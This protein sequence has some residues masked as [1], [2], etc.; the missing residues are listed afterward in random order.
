MD[1]DYLIKKWLNNELNEVEKEAFNTLED[2]EFNEYI[3][4]NAQHFKASNFYKIDDFETFKAKY[5][6][7]KKPIKKLNW[8][9]PL[10]KIACVL[11]ISIGVYF[12]LFS[13][14]ITQIQ[15]VAGEKATVT[16]PDQSKVELNVL[17]SITYD[18]TNWKNNRSLNLEGEAYFMVSKGKSFD[19]KTKH[20]I[21]TVVGTQFNVKERDTYFEVKCFEGMVKVSSN[22]ITKKLVA[23]ETFQILNGKLTQGKMLKSALKWRKNRS[24]FEAIPISNVFAELE[25]QYNIKVI[26]KNTDTTR[27]FTGEFVNNNLEN[28]LIAITQPM[29]ITYE[30]SSSNLVI[31]HGKKN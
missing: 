12:Y 30:L 8:N 5:K 24:V 29:N 19:V 20:G 16:L 21:V 1:K 22:T 6:A 7:S 27:L 25:R 4:N 9:N 13:N 2:A 23:G 15:T 14:S 26:C 10:L 18:A 31:I 11:A 3:I 17:S 28:A